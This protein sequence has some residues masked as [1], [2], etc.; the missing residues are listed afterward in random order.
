ML[1]GHAR[2]SKAEDQDPAAQVVALKA[3]GCERVYEER[4]SGGRW[5]QP[6]LTASWTTGAPVTYLLS[7]S[8]TDSPGPSGRPFSYPLTD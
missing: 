2:V 1:L 5:D 6:E 3:A 8:W 7:G 4:A